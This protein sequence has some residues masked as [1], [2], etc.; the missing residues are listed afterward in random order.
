[1]LRNRNLQTLRGLALAVV[2][3]AVLA[4]PTFAA[5]VRLYIDDDPANAFGI[6]S[7]GWEPGDV[8]AAMAAGLVEQQVG[9]FFSDD[10][11]TRIGTQTL[12]NP[13]TP[14]SNPASPTRTNPVAATALFGFTALDRD[15]TNLSIVL[16]GKSPLSPAGTFYDPGNIGLRIDTADGWGLVRPDPTGDPDLYYLTLEV[17]D[18]LQGETAELAFEYRVAQNLLLIDSGPPPT[19]QLPQF[20]IGYMESVPEMGGLLWLMLPVV[21]SLGRRARL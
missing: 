15:Y 6:G 20:W 11:G 21:F 12:N 18:L 19:F 9:T 4:V 8:A 1:M 16:I 5:S 17:G 3:T 7:F 10:E 13:I 14:S 2:A